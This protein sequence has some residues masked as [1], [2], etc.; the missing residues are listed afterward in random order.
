MCVGVIARSLASTSLF[1]LPF[2][3]PFAFHV[4]HV[5]AALSTIRVGIN[6]YST[7]KM[8]F[9]VY[10]SSL[11]LLYLSFFSSALRNF[12]LNELSFAMKGLNLGSLLS[13]LLLC[14]GRVIS[15]LG[16]HSDVRDVLYSTLPRCVLYITH[17]RL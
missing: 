5:L 14:R 16:I 8:R 3:P 12:L 2:L 13:P 11:A 7:L 17:P 9:V 1:T 10:F 15:I 6:I 4:R